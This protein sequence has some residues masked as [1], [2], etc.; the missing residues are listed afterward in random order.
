MLRACLCACVFVRDYEWVR[1]C[2]PARVCMCM[3]ALVCACVS[4]CWSMCVY[5]RV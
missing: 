5:V 2:V 1:A 4:V 3:R